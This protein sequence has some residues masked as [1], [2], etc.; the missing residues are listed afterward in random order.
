MRKNPKTS[1]VGIATATSTAIGRSVSSETIRRV[2][3]KANYNGR[4]A[5][6]NLFISRIIRDKRIA[7]AKKYSSEPGDFGNNVILVTKVNFIFSEVMVKAMPNS[8][9]L[10]QNNI[11]TVKNRGGLDFVWG[12]Y[13]C[14]Q[15]VKF[16]FYRWHNG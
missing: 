11:P 6:V 3:R 16:S 14:K 9:L 10:P 7:Y 2:L 4:V 5:R 15:S 12:C 13:V 1:A 8:E